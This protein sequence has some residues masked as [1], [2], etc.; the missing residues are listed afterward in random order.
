MFGI[1]VEC[2]VAGIILAGGVIAFFADWR[3]FLTYAIGIVL[4]VVVVVVF[5]D[6]I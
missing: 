4:G 2:I 1:I 6:K 3:Y 5:S